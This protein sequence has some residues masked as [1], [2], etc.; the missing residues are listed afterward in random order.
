VNSFRGLNVS[1]HACFGLLEF[2]SPNDPS[3]FDTTQTIYPF[4]QPSTLSHGKVSV[5]TSPTTVMSVPPLAA[6]TSKAAIPTSRKPKPRQLKPTATL[7][8][9]SSQ[10]RRW[11][12]DPNK[13]TLLRRV[14]N[15]RAVE[16]CKDNFK[17]EEVRCPPFGSLDAD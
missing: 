15:Q 14:I 3:H 12:Y 4:L 13:L 1:Y 2:N 6:S 11:T 16:A 17:E 8:E 9:A 5:S 10:Y 7:Y